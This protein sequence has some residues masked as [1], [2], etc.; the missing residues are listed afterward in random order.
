MWPFQVAWV[1]SQY[2]G[3]VIREEQG[4]KGEEKVV[5]EGDMMG[6]QRHDELLSVLHFILLESNGVISKT[7]CSLIQSPAQF[8]LEWGILSLFL[9]VRVASSQNIIWDWKY[10]SGHI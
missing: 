6:R 9:G 10:C 3:W 7:F 2:G 5:T 4:E 1:S 8:K